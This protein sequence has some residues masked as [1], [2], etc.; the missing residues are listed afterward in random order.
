MNELAEFNYNLQTPSLQRHSVNNSM[1]FMA[2]IFLHLAP[3][4]CT[5]PY[6]PWCPVTHIH[7]CTPH[8][9][10]SLF[11]ILLPFAWP[12]QLDDELIKTME[13]KV[14][15]MERSCFNF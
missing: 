4:G 14:F 2:F 15:V 5:Q 9:T 13:Q 7:S 12:F 10:H 11:R 8:P 6:T 1:G 3:Q